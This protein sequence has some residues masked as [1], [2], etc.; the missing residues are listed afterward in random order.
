MH[1][2]Q[3]IPP[4]RRGSNK[5]T[6]CPPSEDIRQLFNGGEE[7]SMS[8]ST[9]FDEG[10]T[11]DS[12]HIYKKLVFPDCKLIS[13]N[14][15]SVDRSFTG[16][17]N[18]PVFQKMNGEYSCGVRSI[19]VVLTKKQ[20]EEVL[21]QSPQLGEPYQK[22]QPSLPTIPEECLVDQGMA[23][24]EKLLKFKYHLIFGSIVSVLLLSLV[25]LAP[26]FFDLLA[27]FWPL[28]LSTAMFLA[29]AVLFSRVSPTETEASVEKAGEGILD[30]VAGQPGQ[31]EEEEPSKSE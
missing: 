4:F 27:Y 9:L 3:E 21:D 16:Q 18:P 6:L 25:L 2:S 30:F 19:K 7:D 12:Y 14:L 20:L 15:N 5:A 28:F 26:R 23:I 8:S 11:S 10:I 22:W 17:C 31:V 24:P 1:I 29:T 13:G